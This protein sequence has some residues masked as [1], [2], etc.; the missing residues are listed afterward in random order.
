MLGSSIWRDIFWPREQ[1]LWNRVLQRSG[2]VV[3]ADRIE[4]AFGRLKISVWDDVALV[5]KGLAQ[6]V[7]VLV[8][9]KLDL[10]PRRRAAR[11]HV[12]HNLRIP[13]PARDQGVSRTIRKKGGER[14]L[15]RIFA[16]GPE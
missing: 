12:P 13:D 14:Y 4:S 3:A 15:N 5:V 7:A 6:R 2:R 10:K 8:R 1:V 9:L 16:C 11:N